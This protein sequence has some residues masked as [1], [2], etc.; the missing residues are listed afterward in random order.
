MGYTSTKGNFVQLNV[1]STTTSPTYCLAYTLWNDMIAN[2]FSIVAQ[3][4]SSTPD[5]TKLAQT[6]IIILQPS[7]DIDP[8]WATNNWYVGFKIVDKGATL[9]NNNQTGTQSYPDTELQMISFGVSKDDAIPSIVSATASDGTV[10]KEISANGGLYVPIL[11]GLKYPVAKTGKPTITTDNTGK[12]T[13]TPNTD[14]PPRIWTQQTYAYIL[15]IVKRGFVVSIYDQ[16][17]DNMNYNGIYCV[18]R[19]VDKTGTMRSEGN[20]PLY[21]VTNVSSRRKYEVQSDQYN[22]FGATSTSSAA[23]ATATAALADA[24]QKQKDAQTAETTASN[25]YTTAQTN[26]SSAT[27][28]AAAAAAFNQAEENLKA[29][30]TAV[31]NAQTALA[32]ANTASSGNTSVVPNI[33]NIPTNNHDFDTTQTANNILLTPT[34]SSVSRSDQLKALF[35]VKDF[36][37]DEEQGPGPTSTWYGYILREN[38]D[39][40]YNIYENIYEGYIKQINPNSAQ[41]EWNLLNATVYDEFNYARLDT[42]LSYPVPLTGKYLHHFPSYWDGPVTADNG[43][44]LLI[45]PYGICSK[46]FAY[47]DEVD[48]LGVSKADAYQKLQQITINLYSNDRIYAALPSNNDLASANGHSGIRPFILIGGPDFS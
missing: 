34:S 31:S 36:L 37:R 46:R 11:P 32:A 44:Y 21:C 4:N 10:T 43:D 42:T 15:T 23:V 17:L 22:P 2:G 38:D 40:I 20:T 33:E 48:L 25:A 27:E 13:V 6:R 29:A 45:L 12:Q 5:S 35:P 47:T 16:T 8:L 18:Q 39:I 28:V 9:T 41:G 14:M 26:G 30:N 19:G 7:T 3:D 24:Q 1:F